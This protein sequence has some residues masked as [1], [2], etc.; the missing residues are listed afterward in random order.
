MNMGCKENPDNQLRVINLA[1][2]DYVIFSH[3]SGKYAFNYFS[4]PLTINFSVP[5][6]DNNYSV[7]GRFGAYASYMTN[8]TF[9]SR[10]SSPYDD[11]K[12]EKINLSQSA[13]SRMDIG[14]LF[15]L[16]VTKK[17]GKGKLFLEGKYMLGCTNLNTNKYNPQYVN[18]QDFPLFR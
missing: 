8:A 2:T 18:N 11:H 17:L 4:I 6:K 12:K 15:A 14:L 16:G 3:Y 9:T 1:A 10:S 13:I 5:I 7:Y